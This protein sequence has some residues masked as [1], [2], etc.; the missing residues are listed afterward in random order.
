[1]IQVAN[2][3]ADFF[4]PIND[5]DK[6]KLYREIAGEYFGVIT[7]NNVTLFGNKDTELTK[8]IHWKSFKTVSV[9]P[10][11]RRIY[12]ILLIHPVLFR[13]YIRFEFYIKN[14]IL[15]FNKMKIMPNHYLR[16]L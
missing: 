12:V 14:T 11:H 5:I 1:M 15:I 16:I 7:S 13:L 2:Q 9:Y 8:R 4:I 3:L 10:R 6:S